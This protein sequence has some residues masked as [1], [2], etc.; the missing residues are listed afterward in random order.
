MQRMTH[1]TASLAPLPV[2][3]KGEISSIINNFNALVEDQHRSEAALAVSEQRFR[4]LVEHAPDAIYLCNRH[5]CIAYANAAALQLFGAHSPDQL[6]GQSLFGRVHP[7]LHGLVEKSLQ[8]VIE[9]KEAFAP[10]EVK[11][12]RM[13]G[14]VVYAQISAI[15]FDYEN[16]PVALAFARDITDRKLAEQALRESEER[17]RRLAALS[18]EWYWEHDENC[19]MTNMAGWKT[20]KNSIIQRY[21]VGKIAWEKKSGSDDPTRKAIRAKVEAR[22]AF[23]DVEYA[24][25]E[26]DGSVVWYSVSGEP[27]FDEHGTYKGYR[28]TGKDITERKQAEEALRQSRARI[29]KLAAHQAT[30]KEQERKRIARDL[31]DELGQTLLA[32]RLEAATLT[33]QTAAAHPDFHS[34]ARLMLRHIDMAMKSVKAAINDLRPFVLDLGLMAAMEWQVHEFESMSGIACD[35]KVDDEDFDRHLDKSHSTA[36]FRIV[37]ESLTN[38]AQHAKARQVSIV[39]RTEDDQLD[40]TI[41]DNGIGIA[42]NHLNKKNTFGLLG[43]E[44]RINALGGRFNIDS[45]PG[46]GTTLRI[47]MPISVRIEV[48]C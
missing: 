39:I 19:V 21:Q 27:M 24:R 37:Q 10:M 34:S 35:L 5:G 13:D 2:K 28:G 11:L 25:T 42:P 18:S 41:A 45:A 1:G 16:E 30:I 40:M 44:E 23:K 31:H 17:F 9:A 7:D 33:E 32:I 6:V 15:P 43:I 12:Q 3:G 38:I 47:S 22:R 8:S 26:P 14:T 29:R 36:L 48:P 20:K 46:R 4:S